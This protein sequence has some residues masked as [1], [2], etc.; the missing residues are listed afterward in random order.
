MGPW[1]APGSNVFAWVFQSFI[2]ELAQAAGRDPLQFRLDLLGQREVVP[3]T[4]ERGL[5][6][7]V[8]RMRRVL[9]EVAQ[10]ADWGRKKFPRGQGQGI[11]FHFSHR[12]YI[13]EVAEV[14]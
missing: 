14:K 9:T 11:A 7:D 8:G 13:A 12:G 1:R 6:Y 3:A 4:T 10:K 5:P 2:D